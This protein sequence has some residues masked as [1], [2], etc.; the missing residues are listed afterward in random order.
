[1]TD[2][3]GSLVVTGG[4]FSDTAAGPAVQ[5]YGIRVGNGIGG[6][7]HSVG[8]TV[9]FQSDTVAGPLQH[10]SITGNRNSGVE[11]EDGGTTASVTGAP[12]NSVPGN[13]AGG[14]VLGPL[15][16]SVSITS[17]N[18][19]TYSSNIVGDGINIA[20]LGGSLT[21]SG[22]TAS[23]NSVSGL[24]VTDGGTSATFT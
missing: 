18:N 16:G 24:L 2:A 4:S 11:I 8:S 7:I 13:Q 3:C 22:I 12:P 6:A 19:A 15:T 20:S 17:T 1:G 21:V 10:I 9:V 14:V 23:S 5:R